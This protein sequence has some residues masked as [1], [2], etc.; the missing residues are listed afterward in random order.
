MNKAI[1]LLVLIH[2]MTKAEKRYFKLYSNLQEGDKVYLTLFALMEE[3]S[4]VEEVTRRFGVDAGESSFDIAAF[5]ITTGILDQ[6]STACCIYGAGMT[7]RPAFPT[8]WPR[9]RSFSAAACCRPRPK[10]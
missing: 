10:S 6:L 9:R 7:S 2:S 1:S 8:A 5:D 3:C 4:S